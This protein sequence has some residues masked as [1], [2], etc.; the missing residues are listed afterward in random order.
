MT[1]K[2]K[3]SEITKIK[4]IVHRYI[5]GVLNGEI[6]SC[7]WVKLCVQRHMRDLENG[8]ARG[9]V[10]REDKAYHAIKF[11]SFL[12]LWKGSEY[13]GKEY[14]LAPHMMFI[15]WVLMGW[16]KRADNKRRFRKAYLELA[17][18][19]SKTSYAGGLG[20][21]FFVA[22]NE[23]AAEC[24]TAAVSRDQAKLVWINI[25]NL[26]KSSSF[27]KYITYH[28]HELLIE[29]TNSKCEPL[30]S[31]AKSL[32][33][34]DT[35]FGSLDE[36]HAHPTREVHDLLTDSIGAR[37]QPLILII[38]TAGFNQTG[39]CYETRDYLTQV[40]KNTV[41]DDSFFG[42]IFTLDT[43]KDWPDLKELKERLRE[44]EQCEDDWTN[45]DIWVKAAPGLLGT[46]E[47]GKRYGIDSKGKPIPGYM[48]K[49]SD[50]RDK[51]KVAKQMPSAQNNFL[52]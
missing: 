23:E 6:I 48:T 36:L 45:E 32:D 39:I 26:T 29:T 33:G 22:D 30:S 41:Q 19:S 27:A 20:S 8:S 35:H 37:S 21:Y 11:F 25:K 50:M 31:D 34:L 43:K 12:K 2:E 47:S 3:N 16:Y 17:R 14:I 4:K 44:G 51:A 42:I 40:L 7:R 52:P 13:K 10:F 46:S 1:E 15:T 24:Y 28:T 9:L 5:D 49:L 38:T 18:K